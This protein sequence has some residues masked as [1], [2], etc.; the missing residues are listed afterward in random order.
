VDELLVEVCWVE[1]D[2]FMGRV[3]QFKILKGHTANVMAGESMQEWKAMFFCIGFGSVLE[4]GRV[5]I[6]LQL[7]SPEVVVQLS[8][9]V[10]RTAIV[11]QRKLSECSRLARHDGSTDQ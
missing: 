8:M 3:V 9:A 2:S 10:A 11:V 6:L 7:D 1:A 5:N 4:Y